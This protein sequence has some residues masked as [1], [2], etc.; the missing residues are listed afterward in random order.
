MM[1]LE[2]LALTQSQMEVVLS[3]WN[4]EYRENL[5]YQFAGFEK[6]L[7]VLTDIKHYLLSN[8]NGIV[9]GWAFVFTR[10]GQKWFAIILNHNI[11]MLGYGA[12]LPDKLKERE[13]ILNGWVIEHN[14]ALKYNGEKYKS[15]LGFYIKNEFEVS[16]T[17]LETEKLSAVKIIWSR[18]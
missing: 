14:D 16:A 12:L 17:R 10:E 6:Y 8:D 2:T 1:I 5:N 7:N 11:Q 15:P 4:H 9:T 3:L 18:K 13:P